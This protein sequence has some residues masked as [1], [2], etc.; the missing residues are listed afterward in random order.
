M[1][2][3]NSTESSWLLIPMCHLNRLVRHLLECIYT[4]CRVN[5][6][7]RGEVCAVLGHVPVLWGAASELT[8]RVYWQTF[9]KSPEASKQNLQLVLTICV[10]A[11][12]GPHPF[13]LLLASPD[14]SAMSIFSIIWV[15][16]TTSGPFGQCPVRLR[17]QVLPLLS[18]FP[19]GEFASK[20]DLSQP[21]AVVLWGR[22]SWVQLNCSYLLPVYSWICLLDWRLEC[23]HWTLVFPQRYFCPQIISK[24]LFPQICELE[25]PSQ[26]SCSE[27][28][29]LCCVFK[30]KL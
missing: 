11:A 18:L 23:L 5:M 29:L 25:S 22:G 16:Q 15:R 3:P 30:Q 10:V 28:P 1:P 9:W 8:P 7:H 6:H 14:Y 21:S 17:K 2:S 26:A 20:A 19:L 4:I 24:S 27:S 12:V 13:S